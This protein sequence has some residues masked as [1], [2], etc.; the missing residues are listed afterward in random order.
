MRHFALR[1]ARGFKPVYGFAMPRGCIRRQGCFATCRIT[2]A[3]RPRRTIKGAPRLF[4]TLLRTR[5]SRQALTLAALVA[6]AAAAEW[7]QR[8]QGGLEGHPRL[9]D[10][11]SF[12]LGS[13]EV[14]LKGIDAP[15]GRQTCTRGGR[16][17]P[18]GEEARRELQRLIGND[19]IKCR[20]VER[21]Q[22]D[23]HLAYCTAADGRDI[24]AAMVRSGFAVAFGKDYRAEEAEAR[25]TRRGLWSGEFERPRDWRDKHMRR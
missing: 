22:H 11:D 21:D 12:H 4:D 24:N 7:L 14:R 2:A 25:N 20:S 10:G 17:W 13:R 16:Q 3:P 9:T 18:C 1:L 23:R 15:E 5:R 19:A 6:I 8:R